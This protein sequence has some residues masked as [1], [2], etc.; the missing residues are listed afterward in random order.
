MAAC[1]PRGPH[2]RAAA[3]AI[4]LS[5][6]LLS[7]RLYL[8]TFSWQNE[9]GLP[10]TVGNVISTRVAGRVVVRLGLRRSLILGQLVSAVGALVLGTALTPT[11]FMRDGRHPVD[12]VPLRDLSAQLNRSPQKSRTRVSMC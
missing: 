4:F 10:I 3:G 12:V 6:G 7:G 5:Q 9:H 8:L 11:S 1:P 2:L